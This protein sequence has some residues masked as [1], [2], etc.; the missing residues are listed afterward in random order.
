[1]DPAPK[2]ISPWVRVGPSST[3]RTRLPLI[4]SGS[5]TI[6]GEAARTM[7]AAGLCVAMVPLTCSTWEGCA[8]STLLMIAM[9]AMRMLVSPG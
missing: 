6:T 4:R 7:R 1:M 2:G 8:L 3:T 5:L 9:L